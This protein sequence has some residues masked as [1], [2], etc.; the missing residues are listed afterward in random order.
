[1][2]LALKIASIYSRQ[3]WSPPEPCS[4]G[5]RGQVLGM[6]PEQWKARCEQAGIPYDESAGRA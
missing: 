1:M 5:R 6:T 4:F 3:R 2:A